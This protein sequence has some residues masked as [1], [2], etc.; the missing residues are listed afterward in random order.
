MNPESNVEQPATQARRQ[1]AT[2]HDDAVLSAEVR[3]LVRVLRAF[4]P[5]RRASLARIS[6]ADRWH[7]G[8]FDRAVSEA[9]RHGQARELPF[10]FL[11]SDQPGAAPSGPSR[12]SEGRAG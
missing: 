5:L 11:A 6:H 1:R 8:S 3:K 12:S 2:R 7:E 9:V 10:D 4:G